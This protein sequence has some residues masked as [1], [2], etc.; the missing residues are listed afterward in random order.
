MTTYDPAGPRHERSPVEG[1]RPAVS[2]LALIGAG[3][4]TLAIMA[5][6]VVAALGQQ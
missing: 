6:A 3:A 1:D 4:I 2:F 5:A